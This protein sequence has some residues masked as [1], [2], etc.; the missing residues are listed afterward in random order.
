MPSSPR[1]NPIIFA[2]HG[3]PW[4]IH[5]LTYRRTNH[6]NLHVRGY[7]EEG[8]ITTAFD[9]TVLNDLDRFHLVQD[10]RSSAATAGQSRLSQAGNAGQADRTQAIHR[11]LRP[12]YAGNPAWEMEC[13]SPRKIQDE[14]KWA[15]TN[16]IPKAKEPSH[17]ITPTLATTVGDT[18]IKT[19]D[20]GPQ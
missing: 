14:T 8:T 11:Y 6:H 16:T 2:F 7:K 18:Y 5:R 20:Y 9:M 1:L 19:G 3:Y 4:L 13:L 10:D 15:R 17:G 12:R